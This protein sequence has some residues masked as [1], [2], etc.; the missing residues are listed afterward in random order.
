MLRHKKI[1]YSNI[2]NYYN[3][4]P[5]AFLIAIFGNNFVWYQSLL[6]TIKTVVIQTKYELKGVKIW[7]K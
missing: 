3:S 1:K 4:N 5:E 2:W 6:R 7:K